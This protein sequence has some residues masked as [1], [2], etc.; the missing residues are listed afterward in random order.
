[1][2][3][4]TRLILDRHGLMSFIVHPDY[5]MDSRNRSV[6]ESLLAYLAT[7][8]K[9][10]GVWSTIPREVNRWWRQRSAMQLVQRGG[11]WQIEG[12]GSERARIAWASEK[13]GRLVVSL[14]GQEAVSTVESQAAEAE[15]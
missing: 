10:E 5:V 15:A 1:L 13:D 4:Q 3:K 7:L 11:A 6:Y 9:N 14:D 12:Q 2:K 8:V